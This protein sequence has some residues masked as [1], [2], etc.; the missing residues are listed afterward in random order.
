MKS[1]QRHLYNLVINWGGHLASMVVLF[2]LSPYIVG[3][4][5]ASSYGIWT[6]LNVLAGYMGIF[7][8][9]IRASVGRHIALYLGKRDSRGV[10]ETIRAGFGFFT[11][12][13]LVILLVGVLLGWLFPVI[14]NEVSPDHHGLVRYLL[15]VMV[16]N[17]WLS[18]V[19]AIYSS[20]LT[21][22]YR[23]DIARM[24]DFLVLAARTGATVI[25]LESGMGL[26]G[27]V[28]AV[29]VSNLIGLI[30]NRIAAGR[31]YP[32]LR[33]F[34]FLYSRQRFGELFGYGAFAFI[35]SVSYKIIGQS[36]LI[37]VGILL[38]V[39]DVREY[40]VGAMLVYYTMP[41]IGMISST[42]FPLVQRKVS[43]GEMGEINRLLHK[44]IRISLSVGLVVYIGIAFYAEPFIRLWML[45]DGFDRHSVAKAATV[46]AV[47]A[48]SKL[49]TLYL[50][51]CAS[52][53]DA[54]GFVRFNAA[55]AVTEAVVNIAFSLF[56]VMALGWGLAGVAAGTLAARLCVATI[57]VPVF[58][59]R[60][61]RISL[62][63]MASK[64]LV[65]GAAA[66]GAFAV[67]CATAA[68]VFPPSNWQVF[69]LHLVVLVSLW[70]LLV[71]AF[72]LPAQMRRQLGQ[73]L[74]DRLDA[75]SS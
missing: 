2:F 42:F 32:G 12:S 65:P 70:G 8:M 45:Q 50:G 17:I 9:G 27:L 47:L 44:Q 35:S 29:L 56:F 48:L 71:T 60:Q 16:L 30:G 51:P 43:S 68:W 64:T 31:L 49:P 24:V 26:W 74:R 34:P 53:L 62:T 11:L 6:L 21:S 52:V 19:A 41:F 55:R 69:A 46:M 37:L 22:L 28:L 20:V 1:T 39:A 38:S 10:D 3:K 59:A 18:I 36:D 40:N 14:F 23:F 72:I 7:D 33:S 73:I 5:D 58:L 13:G 75:M 63:E 15:P 67:I 61:T 25:A 57:S 4:L 54:M 66:G